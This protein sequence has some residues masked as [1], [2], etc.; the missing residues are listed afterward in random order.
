MELTSIA[1]TT[2]PAGGNLPFTETAVPGS[3]CI[4]HREGSGIIML[5]GITN[6]H[7]ARFLVQYSGNIAVPTGGTVGEISL[8][9]SLNG[10]PLEATRMRVT[11]A[12]AGEFFNIS[13][14]AY[15][16]VPKGCCL[17]VAIENTSGQAVDAAN[18]NII[19][20][21]EA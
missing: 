11:P 13:S 19:I 10:E 20:T 8:A 3:N 7:R 21:R 16:E 6:Q 9:I 2:V 18:N 1:T 15:I 17:S 12:A 4:Q 5:R 14:F